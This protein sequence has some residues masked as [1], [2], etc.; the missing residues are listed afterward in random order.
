MKNRKWLYIIMALALLVSTGPSI[1]QS[2]FPHPVAG[3]FVNPDGSVPAIGDIRYQGY[4]SKDPI[5]TTFKRACG[6]S[7]KWTIDCKLDSNILFANWA[8]GDTLVIVFENVVE[9]G[10][11]QGARTVYRHKT[12]DDFFEILT[13]ISLPVE[14]TTFAAT[15]RS[16]ALAEEVALEWRTAG[17]SNN[18]GFEV[19]RS[20][21]G[22]AYNRIGFVAGAGSTQTAQ[23]YTFVDRDVA[24]GKYYYRLK[25]LDR[26]G[27]FTYSEVKEIMVAAPERYELSQNYPNPFNPRTEIVFRVRQEGLV[28]LK[29]Y[30]ILGREVQTLVNGRMTAGTHRVSVDGR[31][32]PSGMYLYTLSAGDFH[33]VKKMVLIK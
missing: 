20:L 7:G 29:V 30:D 1:A 16:T 5:D 18:L 15:V 23:G 24:V 33:D 8:P 14:M 2:L 21:D 6:D 19:Q 3:K 27:S 11:F 25:Q 32:L 10:P 9:D 31:D 26:D 22:K 17:E 4:L 12:T 13:D 28:V